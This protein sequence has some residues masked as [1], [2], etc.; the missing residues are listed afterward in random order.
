M[1][2]PWMK[3]LWLKIL[4]TGKK[5]KKGKWRRPTWELLR[6]KH[7]KMK[8]DWTSVRAFRTS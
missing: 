3:R 6:H 4:R 2:T 7:L 8:R 1:K 5:P